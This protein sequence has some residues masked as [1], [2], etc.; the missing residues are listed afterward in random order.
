MTLCLGMEW[1]QGSQS[2]VVVGEE[3]QG[4]FGIKKGPPSLPPSRRPASQ[5]ARKGCATSSF[6]QSHSLKYHHK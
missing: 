3:R 5:L 2:E 6:T 4:R 1:E